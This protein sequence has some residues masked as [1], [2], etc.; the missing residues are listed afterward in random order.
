MDRNEI[1]KLIP[2]RDD[3]LILDEVISLDKTSAIGKYKIKGTEFFLRGHYPDKPIVPGT[4]LCEMMAQLLA[5]FVSQYRQGLPLLIEINDAK[6]KKMVG[7]GDE[8]LIKIKLVRNAIRVMTA[9][10]SISTSNIF[11]A[12][13]TLTVAIL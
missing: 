6:L 9:S 11:V 10:C 1:M 13:A 2:H 7:P 4:I 12:S 5:V 8:L 3:M